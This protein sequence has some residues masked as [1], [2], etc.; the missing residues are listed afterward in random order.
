[1]ELSWLLGSRLLSVLGVES[2]I[3]A[4]A[5]GVNLQNHTI[6]KHSNITR[7]LILYLEL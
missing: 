3:I 4:S 7:H 1:M 6:S 2:A 5:Y